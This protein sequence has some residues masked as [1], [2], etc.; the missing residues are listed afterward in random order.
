M[1]NACFNELIEQN[2][3]YLYLTEK[4]D[5]PKSFYSSNIPNVCNS[6]NLNYSLIESLLKT[7]DDTYEFPYD[8]FN[9]IPLDEILNYLELTHQFYLNKK[10]PK[11]EQTALQVFKKYNSSH[12]LLSLLCLFFN[13]Y[14]NRLQEHIR[15]EEKEFFPYIVRLS[16]LNKQS[17]EEEIMHV[18]NS[19]S[20]RQFINN[21]TKIE[22]ELQEVRKV[23][24]KHTNSRSTPLPYRIFLSQLQNFE[25]ELTKHALLEDEILIPMV[26][27]KESQLL[28]EAAKT[29][30]KK[31]NFT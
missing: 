12:Q 6:M 5:I 16:K 15:Y 21:H 24:V 14:K 27:A 4:L 28:N 22:D 26:I 13:D 31:N 29:T 20:V 8:E 10:L 3:I 30:L 11:I 1:K 18:L 2:Q 7:Y 17:T 9:K 23:I 25:V 19:F